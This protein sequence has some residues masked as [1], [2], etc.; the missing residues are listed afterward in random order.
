P[1]KSNTTKRGS[2]PARAR[3]SSHVDAGRCHDRPARKKHGG[4]RRGR[5]RARARQ[6][7]Q[8][9]VRPLCVLQPHLHVLHGDVVLHGRGDPRP[10]VREAGPRK[11]QGQLHEDHWL[12]LLPLRRHHRLLVPRLRL[13]RQELEPRHAVGYHLGHLLLFMGDIVRRRHRVHSLRDPPQ[14]RHPPPVLHLR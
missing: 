3:D 4:A 10:D 13:L 6:E 7:G 5:R 12:L 1:T 14:V 8:V 2:R 9:H 11:T